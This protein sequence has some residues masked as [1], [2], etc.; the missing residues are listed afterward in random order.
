MELSGESK[1]SLPWNGEIRK[2][3]DR[4]DRV[5]QGSENVSKNDH[6]IHCNCNDC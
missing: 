2:Y 5:P 3:P 6:I 1:L 4:S